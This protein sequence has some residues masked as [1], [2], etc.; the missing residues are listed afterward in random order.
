LQWILAKEKKIWPWS[1][2][3]REE[4]EIFIS[5][6]SFG[7]YS[8]IGIIGGWGSN[9][10]F[11]YNRI[12]RKKMEYV[13]D[14]DPKTEDREKRGICWWPDPPKGGGECYYGL[15]RND[16]PHDHGMF[17]WY[18]G[19][20]Y[21]GMWTDGTMDGYGVYSYSSIGP[22]PN[23]TFEGAYHAG[24]RHGT[25]VYRY[26]KGQK[27]SVYMGEWLMGVMNGAGLM[28]YHD[29]EHYMG[30]WKK[31]LKHGMGV[32]FWGPSAG[33]CAGDK[34]EGNFKD[35][36]ASGLGVTVFSDGGW[37]KGWYY[38]GKMHGWGVMRTSDGF[39]YVGNWNDDEMHGEIM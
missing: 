5:S 19:D 29:G 26:G 14:R 13:G 3:R 27:G 37:H 6:R 25:G 7:I 11:W 1:I 2:S 17:K 39:E 18:D 38:K 36:T 20:R 23:D 21:M 31:D 32:Y 34:Y 28:Y 22:H 30:Q 35:G 15:W 16:K 33:D 24:L 10:H 9:E 8:A 12:K 4:I